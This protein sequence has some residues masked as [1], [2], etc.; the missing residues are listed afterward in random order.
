MIFG[1]SCLSIWMIQRKED[2]S[3]WGFVIGIIGQ[4]FWIYTTY[5]AKQ[6][7]ILAVS[8]WFLYCYIQGISKRF[9]N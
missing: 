7:G 3:K 6:W 8:I 2:W 1:S 4:P 9:F 5:S